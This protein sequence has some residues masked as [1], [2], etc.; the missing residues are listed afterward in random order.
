MVNMIFK[1]KNQID[2]VVAWVH[3]HKETSNLRN[4][5]TRA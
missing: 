5:Y 3:G 4:Q 2:F 1:M